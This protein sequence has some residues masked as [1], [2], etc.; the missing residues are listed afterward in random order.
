[1][2]HEPGAMA[3]PPDGAPP[4]DMLEWYLWTHKVSKNELI[5]RTGIPQATIYRIC[6]NESNGGIG[7]WM[8]IANALGCRVSDILEPP[9]TP[10]E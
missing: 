1:M 4:G 8:R 2:R 7:L 6:S 9:R 10:T 3:M 5:R